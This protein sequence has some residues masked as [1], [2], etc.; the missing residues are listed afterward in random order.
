MPLKKTRPL[1]L[2]FGLLSLFFLFSLFDSPEPVNAQCGSQAS[3]CKNCHEVQGNDPVNQD[4]TDWHQPHAFG[5]F[6][7][8]C[9][10]GN[11]QSP[12]QEEAHTGMVAPLSNVKAA[13]STCHENYQEL[14]E[15]YANTLGVELGVGA[16]APDNS[17]SSTTV[18]QPVQVF[19]PANECAADTAIYYDEADL[20]DYTKQYEES[21]LGIRDLNAGNLILGI[22][23]LGLVA[24]G[25][26]FVSLN[27]GW[28]TIT[29]KSI[30]DSIDG[31]GLDNVALLPL[32]EK[33]DPKGRQA[34][35]K[36][37]KKPAKAA[38]VFKAVADIDE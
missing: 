10:A 4:G 28:V 14:A 11:V 19:S 13:C 3:S 22:M 8:F 35:K 30:P 6:C 1:L 12:A 26:L 37:L 5:D 20:I 16:A 38:K 2:I 27:E 36:L 25:G 18:E 17:D 15:G 9:H 32:I 31:F 24:G 7:E 29:T 23:V 33:V 21:V 34:L